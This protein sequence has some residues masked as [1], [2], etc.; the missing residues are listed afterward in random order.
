MIT[1]ADLVRAFEHDFTRRTPADHEANLRIVEALYEEA[2]LMGAWPPADALVGIETD[3]RLA[4]ALR[5][6]NVRRTP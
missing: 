5:A 3:I 6:L 4:R 2:R 1:N